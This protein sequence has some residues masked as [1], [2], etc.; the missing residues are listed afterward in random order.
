MLERSWNYLK[1]RLIGSNDTSNIIKTVLNNRGIEDSNTYLNL[2]ADVVQDYN[3]L[4]G[5]QDAVQC[6]TKHYEARDEIAQ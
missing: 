3:N 4:S 5:M 2:T 1:Y 6:F